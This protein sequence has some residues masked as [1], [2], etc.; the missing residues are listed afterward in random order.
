MD[1]DNIELPN[2]TGTVVAPLGNTTYTAGELIEDL[3]DEQ[4]E[5]DTTQ[6]GILSLIYRDTTEFTDVDQIVVI[7][8]NSNEG[9]IESPAEITN[10]SPIEAGDLNFSQNLEFIYPIEDGEELDSLLYNGGTITITYESTFDVDLEFEM[11][12]NDIIDRNT[13]LPIVL[14]AN[15]APNGTGNQSQT[16]SGHI[17]ETTKNSTNENVFTGVFNGTLKIPEGGSVYATD[18]FQYRIDI[19]DATFETIYGYFGEKNLS[20]DSQV[21]EMDFFDELD[22]DI[23]FNNPEVRLTID[24]SFGVTMGLE[25]NQIVSTNADGDQV[26]L[27]G[28]ITESPQF[29][30]APDIYSVGSTTSSTIRIN[31]SNSNI[32]ELFSNAPN[33]LD[34]AINA[35]S[36]YSNS[37]NIV[38]IEDRNFVDQNS[39]ATTIME[40]ELPLELQISNIARNIDYSLE[41]IDFEE[42]DSLFLRIKT[43]NRLPLS[44]TIDLQFLDID[45]AVVYQLDQVTVFNSPEVPSNGKVQDPSENISFVKIY[46]EGIEALNNEPT[47]RLLLNIDSYDAINDTYVK[48]YAD[49]ELE[50]ILGVQATL[51]IEL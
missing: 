9:Q 14:N 20:I 40:I 19:T 28:S 31:N 13:G 22:G 4:L 29:V 1:F 50:I 51:D 24:N 39:S 5:V 38:P 26:T 45:S 8:D 11:V 7:D 43:L 12:I 3:Q 49:Y 46:G 10:A 6:A 32:G 18:V 47:L 16:L 36:N 33:R 27:S 37:N 15:V 48:I 30:N 35:L 2:Y 41:D 21:I 23:K 25:L 44:G 17:T 42:A 34:F